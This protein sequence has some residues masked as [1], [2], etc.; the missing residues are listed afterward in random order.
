MAR[1]N[2]YIEDTEIKLLT[3][4][5]NRVDKWASL[6]L[7][8][9][10]V[11]QGLV[12]QEERVSE[13]IKQLLK[14]QSVSAHN[15]TLGI[16]GLNSIFRIINIPEVSKNLLAEA[17][18]NEAA[19]VL[20]VP[21]SQ[22]YYSYQLLP[23]PKGEMRIFL[24][25]YPRQVTDT[26][27][28]TASKAGLK[29]DI[30]DLAPLAL[31]R[32]VNAPRAVIVNSWLTFLDIVIM[33]ERIPQVIRSV[34]LPVESASLQDR[35]PAIMEEINRTVTFYNSSNA[36]GVLDKSVP[37]VVC[38]DLARQEASWKPLEN[39]GY[40]VQ[41]FKPAMEY[42][43]VFD[44][45][46]YA[47]DCGLALKG[48]S[49]GGNNNN[50]SIIDFNALPDSYKPASFSWG[51]V[52]AP[53]GLV[54]ALG[55][56]GWGYLMVQ[57]IKDEAS[58]LNSQYNT[59]MVDVAKQ[60]SENSSLMKKISEEEAAAEVYPPQAAQL[61]KQIS[62]LQTQSDFFSGFTDIYRDGLD[63]GNLDVREIVALVPSG[64]NLENIDGGPDSYDIVGM[65]SD[66][67]T[68]LEYGRALEASG[69]FGMVLVN[70]IS[71]VTMSDGT[72]ALEFEIILG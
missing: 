47:V 42:K 4:S 59:L 15:I 50:Y 29:P 39:L 60:G 49:A 45:T 21:L 26:L 5:G 13:A 46:Q 53:V 36:G 37:L 64:I 19:R 22:V 6:T 1:V 8:E 43:G 2:L 52:L 40:P 23:A 12:L 72:T 32:C 17:I 48:Q 7:E 55:A 38:G 63:K 34:S 25:A 35:L 28:A 9:G 10:L 54:V 20:P 30:I 70:S 62:Q 11:D 71:D 27:I 67:D 44:P 56:L 51:R 69:R 58:R 65:A 16:T 68:V 18:G 57:D 61:E 3:T 66:E 31:A 24:A 33:T 41:L 14:A